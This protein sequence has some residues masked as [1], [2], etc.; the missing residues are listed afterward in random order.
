LL[1]CVC[2]CVCVCG[3]MRYTHGV[4]DL[5]YRGSCM[6]WL[7]DTALRVAALKA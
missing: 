4:Q 3:S 2:V 6:L 5:Y 1:M 7:S